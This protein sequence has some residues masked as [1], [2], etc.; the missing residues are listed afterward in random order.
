MHK[1]TGCARNA[2]GSPQ[3]WKALRV[4][5]LVVPTLQLGQGFRI[6]LGLARRHFRP[7]RWRQPSRQRWETATVTGWLK[8]LA[9]LQQLLLIVT[10]SAG[11]HPLSA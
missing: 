7:A 11:S 3:I 1:A 10:G 6:A 9:H 5:G 8:G 4:S 2:A